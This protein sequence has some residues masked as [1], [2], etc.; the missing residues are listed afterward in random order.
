MA[1]VLSEPQRPADWSCGAAATIW[2]QNLSDFGKTAAILYLSY[3]S[4]KSCDDL[5]V[6]HIRKL[7]TARLRQISAWDGFLVFLQFIAKELSGT[8]SFKGY[9][10]LFASQRISL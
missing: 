3:D 1:D 8:L 10:N 4:K 5:S 6:L 2:P 9:T 7:S